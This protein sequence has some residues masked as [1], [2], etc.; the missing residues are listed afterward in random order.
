MDAARKLNISLL[1]VGPVSHSVSQS[2]VLSLFPARNQYLSR[3]W[4]VC[5]FVCIVPVRI[6]MHN[7]ICYKMLNPICSCTSIWSLAAVSRT[8]A[9]TQVSLFIATLCTFV[10]KTAARDAQFGL[11]E[12]KLYHKYC[13]TMY[14]RATLAGNFPAFPV[15]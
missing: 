6:A 8:S 10:Q 14:N 7:T 1:T 13:I 9:C 4:F 12:F 5:C 11:N 15:S 3:P 2:G